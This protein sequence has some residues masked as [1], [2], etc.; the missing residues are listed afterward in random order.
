[1]NS[2]H[3]IPR[4]KYSNAV[5]CSL[6]AIPIIYP[7]M[8]K[9][10]KILSETIQKLYFIYLLLM[11]TFKGYNSDLNPNLLCNILILNEMNGTHGIKQKSLTGKKVKCRI[12]GNWL[13]E[14]GFVLTSKTA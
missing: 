7:W 4:N 6:K 8:K 10:Q 9:R 2:D 3:L 12:I 11:K 14:G 13:D 1:M 5:L